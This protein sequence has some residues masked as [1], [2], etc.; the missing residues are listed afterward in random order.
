[1]EDSRLLGAMRLAPYQSR[2][3]FFSKYILFNIAF[4]IWEDGK[5]ETVCKGY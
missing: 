3:G 1:V 2:G 4:Y 5:Y